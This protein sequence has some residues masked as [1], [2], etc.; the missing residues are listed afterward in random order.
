[1]KGRVKKTGYERH[2]SELEWREG[3]RKRCRVKYGMRWSWEGQHES[4]GR[5]G[6]TMQY[7]IRLILKLQLTQPQLD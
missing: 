1:M 2:G 5:S 3:R 7:N 4:K 6:R